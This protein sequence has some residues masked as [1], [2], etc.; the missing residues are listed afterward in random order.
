MRIVDLKAPEQPKPPR[1]TGRRARA[2]LLSRGLLPKP[3][4]VGNGVTI[5]GL[6]ASRRLYLETAQGWRRIREADER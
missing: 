5:Q 2:R 3:H 4:D 6:R 1:L